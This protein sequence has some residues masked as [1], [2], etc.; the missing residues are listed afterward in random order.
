MGSAGFQRA[1]RLRTN[2]LG[3][4]LMWFESASIILWSSLALLKQVDALRGAFG[5][6]PVCL[7]TVQSADRDFVHKSVNAV[8]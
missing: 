4:T 8:C 3:P 1:A 5:E 2:G 6:V 7:A